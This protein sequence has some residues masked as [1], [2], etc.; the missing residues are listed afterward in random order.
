MYNTLRK[1]S[2]EKRL[3]LPVFENCQMGMSI[4]MSLNYTVPISIFPRFDFLILA[5]NQ[6][7][8]HLNRL[9]SYS[10]H[11][12]QPKVIIRT[13]VGSVRPL[14]PSFQHCNDYTEAFTI[15]LDNMEVIKLTE[16]NQIY[17]SY[18]RAYERNDGKSTLL[19]EIADY[20]N[21]K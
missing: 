15:M 21:E 1:V 5:T 16:P 19:V 2:K 13:G 10:S 17:S 11:E 6:L 9:K 3:E 4:G 8:N 12:Y 14:H 18:K 20:Y 7:V